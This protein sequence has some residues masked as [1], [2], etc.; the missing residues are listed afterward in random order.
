MSGA[1][2]L[3]AA[4]QGTAADETEEEKSKEEK[5][6]E[7]MAALTTALDGLHDKGGDSVAENG[8]EMEGALLSS[9]A[10]QAAGKKIASDLPKS[11]NYLIAG[12]D[13]IVSVDKWLMFEAQVAG[14]CIQLTG[15]E[16][17]V[18]AAPPPPAIDGSGGTKAGAVLPVLTALAPL[19]SSIMRSE[20]EISALGGA[21]DDDSL[22]ARAMLQACNATLNPKPKCAGSQLFTPIRLTGSITTTKPFRD[23]LTL[24][25]T[26]DALAKRMGK[27]GTDAQ[28]AAISAADS[29]IAAQLS[30]DAKGEVALLDVVR[31]HRLEALLRTLP[32]VTVSVEKAGG[33]LLKRKALD[34]AL[35]GA[36]SVR[37][38][39]GIIVSYT[40]ETLDGSGNRSLA[41]SAMI[42]CQ[43]KLT[44]LK[45]VHMLD[46]NALPVCR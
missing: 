15:S 40:V 8:G 31:A 11:G 24:Q 41:H 46:G 44:E 42:A 23:L 3:E 6:I 32:V 38:S 36:P 14:L 39:G 18:A 9:F 20:T 33:T 29:F 28:K 10:M 17:C 30:A 21:L 1:A 7:Q 37:A 4:I 45:K 5:L 34:V 43:T 26:R 35:F 13:D 16:S 19:I 2:C 27:K 25:S 12:A 22:L